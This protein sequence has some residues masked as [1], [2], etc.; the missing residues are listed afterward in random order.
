MP[1]ARRSEETRVYWSA[2]RNLQSQMLTI[3]LII[4]LGV[5]VQSS[6]GFGL[7]LVTMPLLVSTLGIQTAAPLVALV[8]FLAETAILTRYRKAF[9]FADV[10]HVIVGA[11]VGIPIGVLAIRSLYSK[12]VTTLLGVIVIAYALYAL[13]APSLPTLEGIGWSYIFGFCAG[14]LGGAYNTGGPPAV[15]YG[16]CRQWPPD[17]F[18]SN[19]Q[20]FF[21]VTGLVVIV[22]HLLSGNMTS[23]V[24]QNLLF[25]LPGLIAGLLCGFYLSKRINPRLFHKLVL[26]ALIVLGLKLI[27]F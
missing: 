11:V 23:G 24:L 19:L 15:I 17:E 5:F 6:I 10:K 12:I 1:T 13:L 14:I 20:G 4:F 26:A 3:A 18:K 25:A 9:S 21:L 22:S 2:A 7:A 27:F 8:A 16:D